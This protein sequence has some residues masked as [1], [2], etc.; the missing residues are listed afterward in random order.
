MQTQTTRNLSPIVVLF[1]VALLVALALG[2][3]AVSLVEGGARAEAVAK[4]APVATGPAVQTFHIDFVGATSVMAAGA[5]GLLADLAMQARLDG[6]RQVYITSFVVSGT[7]DA[8]GNESALRRAKVVKH[9][10]EANGVDPSSVMLHRAVQ[11][12][13]DVQPARSVE[14]VL[15]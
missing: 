9:A 6:G 14:L 5:N 1:A 8:A 11:S 12:F 4:P 7:D 3:R 13:G 15:R 2:L 10:L